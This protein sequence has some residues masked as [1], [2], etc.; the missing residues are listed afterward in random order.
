MVVPGGPQLCQARRWRKGVTFANVTWSCRSFSA[1]C[2]RVPCA[3]APSRRCRMLTYE[4]AQTLGSLDQGEDGPTIA[5]C[6]RLCTSTRESFR[7]ARVQV[8]QVADAVVANIEAN[9][10]RWVDARRHRIGNPSR[11]APATAEY[12]SSSTST[13]AS[14]ANP[15]PISRFAGEPF[16]RFEAE[17]AQQHRSA[18]DGSGRVVRP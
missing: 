9:R 17:A 2:Q 7:P 16:R 4:E 18:E 3:P 6:H 13:V 11:S 8:R 14:S 5:R 1:Q 10:T 15:T 12:R